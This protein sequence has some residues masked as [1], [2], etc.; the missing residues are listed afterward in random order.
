MIIEKLQKTCPNI[1]ISESNFKKHYVNES[2]NVNKMI[3]E[4]L[5]K[6]CPN[7]QISESNFKKHYMTLIEKRKKKLKKTHPKIAKNNQNLSIKGLQQLVQQ[8]LMPP[9]L[10]HFLVLWDDSE[11]S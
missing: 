1:Q 5:Q 11:Y 7:I 8:M 10:P 3:I 2:K 9:F 6:T 4:K